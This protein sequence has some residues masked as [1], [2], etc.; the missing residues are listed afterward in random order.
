MLDAELVILDVQQK[1][2]QQQQ[3]Q[4]PSS[5]KSYFPTSPTSAKAKSLTNLTGLKLSLVPGSSSILEDNHHTVNIS[6]NM[7]DDERTK[8]L[9]FLLD[10]LTSGNSPTRNGGGNG[11]VGNVNGYQLHVSIFF[12]PES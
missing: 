9:E 10:D 11:G 1:Y 8:S 4:Q 7:D 6:N 3:Q 5:P 12:I 2:Q